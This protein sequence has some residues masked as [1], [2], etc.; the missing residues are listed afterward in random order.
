MTSLQGRSSRHL[1]PAPQGNLPLRCQVG[2]ACEVEAP[3][4]S[5][6]GAR[7]NRRRLLAEK[8]ATPY[9]RRALLLFRKA[10]SLTRTC[11][12]AVVVTRAR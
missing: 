4:L 1:R 9:A 2:G 6:R 3:P 11:P 8:R 5:R 10:A 7:F 12:A